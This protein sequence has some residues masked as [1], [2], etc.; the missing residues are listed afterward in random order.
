MMQEAEITSFLRTIFIIVI[1][2]YG[3]KM[4]GKYMAPIILNR[5]A[6]KFEERVKN[7]KQQ[8]QQPKQNVGETV[9]DKNPNQSRSSN[10]T[11]GE[12]V[13]YEEVD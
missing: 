11:V 7:Q 6:K 3:L 10:N 12:Y 13:D 2:Y 4:I 8:R 5:A 1:V 9:I